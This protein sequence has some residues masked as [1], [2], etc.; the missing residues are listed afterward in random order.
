MKY[1]L[2][3]ALL[4]LDSK[5]K[6]NNSLIDELKEVRY[7]K[8]R[9]DNGEKILEHK[10]HE[11]SVD[12]VVK[13]FNKV[14][15]EIRKLKCYIREA[16]L[17]IIVDYKVDNERISLYEALLLIKEYR[18]LYDIYSRLGTLKVTSEIIV[19][20]K[21]YRMLSDL[22]YEQICEPTYN[23]K[24]YREKAEKLEVLITKLEIAI[25]QSNYSN[26]IDIDGIEI[27]TVDQDLD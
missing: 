26:E 8:Y 20:E 3:E 12:S 18:K 17:R 6:Q 21:S 9:K 2:A 14:S 19:S 16:N 27:I 5:I 11:S 13:K 15:M 25:N 7:N 24:K 23:T 1:M 4:I 22:S 10:E